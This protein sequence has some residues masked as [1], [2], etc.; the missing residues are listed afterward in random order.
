MPA[1][2]VKNKRNA[3]RKISHSIH[4][5]PIPDTAKGG[6]NATAI[7]TPAKVLEISD[8]ALAYAPAIPEPTAIPK[9]NK[10]GL[11]LAIISSLAIFN[12]VS[13]VINMAHK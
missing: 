10:L 9:S 7:A 1:R 8:L 13:H 3:P 4:P 2:L 6:T 11:T 5:N 12:G